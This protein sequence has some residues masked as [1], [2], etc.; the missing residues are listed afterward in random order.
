MDK[1][2]S[3]CGNPLDEG[4]A[5][6]DN[7]GAKVG[8]AQPMQQPQPVT[9]QQSPAPDGSYSQQPTQGVQYPQQ[10]AQEVQ[11]PQQP[12]YP[13]YNQNTPQYTPQPPKKRKLWLIPVI[14]GAV[15]ALVALGLIIYGILQPSS[16][17]DRKR[18]TEFKTG[19][20]STVSVTEALTEAPTEKSTEAPTDP[21]TEA[22]T[23]APVKLPYEDGLSAP[24]ASDFAWI[25]DA[26]SGGLEG[27]SLSNDDLLG[28]WKGEIIIDGVW[29][30]VYIT[31]GAD[32]SVTVEP[33][34]INYG[35]GWEDESGE[36]PYIFKGEF[37]INSVNGS[38][39]YGSINLYRFTEN[40]GTQYG[41]GTFSIKNK[42]SADVYMVRP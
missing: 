12:Q 34:Q 37:D 19:V 28:K 27:K 42:S 30:L 21:P 8:T 17:D 4:A 39:K 1:F 5:F 6:C 32:A 26:Q 9:D 29:E 24:N 33:Y 14:I 18:P 16:H 23:Q 40:H 36:D 22:P 38:G 11:Y 20:Q 13:M 15:V 41:I 25:A 7:C 31:I 35:D 2:C 3:N 10:P